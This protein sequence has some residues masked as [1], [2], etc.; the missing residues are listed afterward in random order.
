MVHYKVLHQQLPGDTIPAKN[1]NRINTCPMQKCQCVTHKRL[2]HKLPTQLVLFM[3]KANVVNK[4]GDQVLLRSLHSL[5]SSRNSMSFM[6]HGYV[7]LVHQ[8]QPLEPTLS[9]FNPVHFLIP[10]FSKIRINTNPPFLPTSPNSYLHF[11]LSD[12]TSVC[13]PHISHT[14]Y[15]PIPSHTP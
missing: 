7:Q 12:Q 13:T 8:I 6:E 2:P 5:T 15:M 4:S 1:R 3:Q 11:G 14:C 9:L 10:Y